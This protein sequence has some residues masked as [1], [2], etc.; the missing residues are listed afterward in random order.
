MMKP[1]PNH[2]HEHCDRTL[3]LHQKLTRTD[4]FSEP[5]V[6]IVETHLHH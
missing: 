1:F 2:E 6:V 4:P 3:E 5:P